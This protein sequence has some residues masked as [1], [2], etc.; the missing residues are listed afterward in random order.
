[1]SSV[2]IWV[3]LNSMAGLSASY[4]SVLRRLRSFEG[5]EPYRTNPKKKSR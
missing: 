2:E 3:K 1:M 4:S 5:Y